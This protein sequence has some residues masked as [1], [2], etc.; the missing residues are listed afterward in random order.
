MLTIKALAAELGISYRAA[1]ELVEVRAI[2]A[3]DLRAPG[4]ARSAWRIERV[5]VEAFLRARETLPKK[6]GAERAE[7]ATSRGVAR[8]VR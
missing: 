4:A 5:D 6:H 7:R 2:R 8:T 3:I 1:L